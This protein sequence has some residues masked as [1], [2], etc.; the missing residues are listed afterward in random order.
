MLDGR[1]GGEKGA[2][3]MNRDY[4]APVFIR[5]IHQCRDM[6]DA[7]IAHQYVDAAVAAHGFFDTAVDLLLIGHIHGDGNRVAA[8]LFDVIRGR[9]RSIQFQIGDTDL[10]A[11][12]RES[13]R[14]L[15]A[16]AAGGAGNDCYL[17]LHTHE[18]SPFTSMTVSCVINRKLKTGTR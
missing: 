3:E 7:G 14:N 9:R 17:V 15:L 13:N 5:Q 4:L 10:G 2:V 11:F 1:L 6:L 18:S 12:A 16:D 8:A